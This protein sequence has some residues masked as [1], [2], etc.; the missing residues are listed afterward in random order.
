MN[1]KNEV[2]DI[3]G[4]SSTR[5]Q[6]SSA[7]FS[8]QDRHPDS[9][10]DHETAEKMLHTIKA[11]I[12]LFPFVVGTLIIITFVVFYLSMKTSRDAMSQSHNVTQAQ[13]ERA[14]Q[15]NMHLIEIQATLYKMAT[16]KIL[17]KD[18][19]GIVDRKTIVDNV[20]KITELN[21]DLNMPM[22]IVYEYI[23]MVETTLKL[24]E[25]N[26]RV[27]SGNIAAVIGQYNIIR[28]SLLNEL[29]IKR[30]ASEISYYS[31]TKQYEIVLS[32]VIA[33]AAVLMSTLAFLTKNVIGSTVMPLAAI[34][35]VMQTIADGAL[36]PLVPHIDRRDEV[37][38]MARAVE[39]FRQ[40][41]IK[42]REMNAQ[43]AALHAKSSDLQVNISEV[44]KAAMVGDFTKRI[45]KI[46]DDSDLDRFAAQVNELVASVD[47]GVSETRRVVAALADGNLTEV[48]RG[49]F[50]GAFGELQ[51]NVNGT[52]ATLR[53]VLSEVR[54]A[55]D[56]I[57]AGA[58]ELRTG[59]G[60]LSKRTEQQAASLEETAAALEEVTTA[61]KSS[62]QRAHETSSMVDLARQSAEQSSTV[63]RHAVS[64]M[65]LIE[66]AS[67]EINQITNVIDEI[68]FQTNL[69]ALNAG[70]EAARAGD[71]GRGFAVV[72]SE[73]RSLAQRSAAAAKDIK[74]LIHRSGEHVVSGVK[75]VSATGDALGSIQD[76]VLN[77]NK[78][79]HSIAFTAKEQSVGLSEVNIAIAQMD[80][81]TQQNA[82]M[83]EESTAAAH[84]LSEQAANLSHLIARFKL[85]EGAAGHIQCGDL[86]VPMFTSADEFGNELTGTND[87]LSET[88][89]AYTRHGHAIREFDAA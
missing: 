89:S 29:Q 50:Q 72:A 37:G 23:H 31:Q 87:I 81:V 74:N 4:D 32:I 68:A 55:I 53:A 18:Y 40:N 27:A 10:P 16:W 77:I 19:S 30:Q 36:K 85:D 17:Q 13:L 61:V 80:Q 11:K 45:N 64:A 20:S 35:K 43:E 82:A 1:L 34:T 12:L 44:V 38:E 49:G 39:V 14:Y 8:Q 79:M 48:M 26:P 63:V 33:M 86:A 2:A 15:A 78:Q 83:V 46:Y 47:E 24:I 76:H 22:D 5:M 9:E 62:S 69:L 6:I 57:N 75:L 65:K 28:D 58:D 7:I 54:T 51:D 66:D 70:V 73:V 88:G 60:D 42:V 84:H 59:S 71:A 41:G 3:I 52:M 56:A 67:S 25:K 21:S